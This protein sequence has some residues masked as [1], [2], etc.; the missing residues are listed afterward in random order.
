MRS[1]KLLLF[2]GSV[3]V[4][5]GVFWFGKQNPTAEQLISLQD[6]GFRAAY[7]IP[8][9]GV[10]PQVHLIV[11]S[12]EMDNQGTAGIPHYVEHLAW[13]NSVGAKTSWQDRDTNA[14]T[15]PEQTEYF[16]ASA[17]PAKAVA[18]LAMVLAPLPADT[19]FMRSERNV[20]LREYDHRFAENPMAE[21]L[22]GSDRV[23]YRN[24]PRQRSVIGTKPDIANFSLDEARAW[25]QATHRRDNAIWV[26]YGPITASDAK[27]YLWQA[28][29]DLTSA[30]APPLLPRGFVQA[31]VETILR[32]LTDPRFGQD[33][34][35][36]RKTVALGQDLDY[37]AQ[38]AQI[39]LLYDILDSTLQG[40]Y[41]K[42]L[43]FS[44]KTAQSYFF[45]LT[46]LTTR[47]LEF[48][49]IDARPDAGVRLDQLQS[50]IGAA[51][52]AVAR[53]GIPPATFDRVKMRWLKRLDT[54]NPQDE[55]LALTQEAIRLGQNPP[56]FDAF[57]DAAQLVTIDDL[58][59]LVRAMAGQGRIVI[60]MVSTNKEN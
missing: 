39:S 46:N 18:T 6:T 3:L 10:E 7:L 22:D 14:F 26:F 41:A 51:V 13:L 11:T 1:P 19:E 15:L 53:D 35:N 37:V 2:I 21:V 33:F 17:D 48:G 25:H 24:D 50:A 49:F 47:D 8:A 60:D 58:N 45:Y 20:I 34:L 9:D 4:A 42:P 56:S 38:I 12:G 44:T 30:P 59:V 40:G 31:P 52:Q 54:V 57:R 5:L 43:R 32:P 36:Y 29:P 27:S 23:L 55:T 16:V 28:F